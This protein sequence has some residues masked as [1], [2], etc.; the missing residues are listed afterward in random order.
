MLACGHNITG[1]YHLKGIERIPPPKGDISADRW[2]AGSAAVFLL[3]LFERS[4][5][6]IAGGSGLIPQR[7]GPIILLFGGLAA[8][9]KHCIDRARVAFHSLAVEHAQA[10]L[11]FAQRVEANFRIGGQSRLLIGS[12]A[13][14]L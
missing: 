11:F 8:G 5:G 10:L 12:S 14:M 1:E 2:T 13:E 3:V 4:A 7:A 6:R 9:E